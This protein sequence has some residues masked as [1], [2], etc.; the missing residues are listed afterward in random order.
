VTLYHFT[1]PAYVRSIL[2][3]GL[4][5]QPDWY[6]GMPLSHDAPVVWLTEQRIRE[7]RH[8]VCRHMGAERGQSKWLPRSSVRIA[9]D[10]PHHLRPVHLSLYIGRTALAYGTSALTS[11]LPNASLIDGGSSTAIFPAA[12]F[13]PDGQDLG[14]HPFQKRKAAR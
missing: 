10:L 8:Y 7:D 5:A 4:I 14:V 13:H 6:Y 11:G 9:V 2:E 1:M 3:R 12:T